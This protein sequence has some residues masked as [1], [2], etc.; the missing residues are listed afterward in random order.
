MITALSDVFQKKCSV[1]DNQFY[2]S[3]WKC[4]HT[5][6][7]IKSI[8]WKEGVRLVN[9][10]LKLHVF[11]KQSQEEVKGVEEQGQGDFSAGLK[12]ASGGSSILKAS[13]RPPTG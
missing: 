4:L 2:L 8:N 9:A 6:L 13:L 10:V 5:W 12:G 3:K 11:G 7:V 1:V